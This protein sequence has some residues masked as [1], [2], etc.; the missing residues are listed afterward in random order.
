MNRAKISLLCFVLLLGQ[1]RADDA[2]DAGAAAQKFTDGYLHALNSTKANDTTGYLEKTP[3]VTRAYRKALAKFYADALKKDPGYGY[4]ADAVIWGNSW[5]ESGYQVRRVWVT[6]PLAFVFLSTRNPEETF[7]FEARLVKVDG[8]WVI[9]G[10]GQ[11]SGGVF[12]AAAPKVSDEA[13][14]KLLPGRWR[15]PRHDYVY[16]P[17]GTWQMLEGDPHG[18]WKIKNGRLVSQTSGGKPSPLDSQRIYLLDDSCILS[19][20]S[21]GSV[22]RM[23]R[24][25]P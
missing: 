3:L 14:S 23:E 22:F 11:I 8:R 19:A 25:K 2:S 15:S 9:D 17:D 20:A 10:T 6:G 7:A 16:Q 21:D 24:V 18:T 12:D 1:L 13:L 4:G 5:P